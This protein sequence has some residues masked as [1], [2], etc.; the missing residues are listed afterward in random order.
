MVNPFSVEKSNP[1]R[2]KKVNTILKYMF[3]HL[4]INCRDIV[5]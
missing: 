2:R 1:F 3:V 5:F 4:V